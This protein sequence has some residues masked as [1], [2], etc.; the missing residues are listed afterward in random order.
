M[1][2]LYLIRLFSKLKKFIFIFKN[3]KRLHHNFMKTVIYRKKVYKVLDINKGKLSRKLE[4]IDLTN[5]KQ[6]SKSINFVR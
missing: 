4:I 2:R 1:L 3:Y 5:Q 6:T